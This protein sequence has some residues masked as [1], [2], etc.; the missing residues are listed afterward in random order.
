MQKTFMSVAVIS[1]K[2]CNTDITVCDNF[3]AVQWHRN[4]IASWMPK[5]LTYFETHARIS[6]RDDRVTERYAVS[7]TGDLRYHSRQK[8]ILDR[9]FL[10]QQD[11]M[12]YRASKSCSSIDRGVTPTFH[13]FCPRREPSAFPVVAVLAESHFRPDQQNPSIQN[14]Y[15]AVVRHVLVHHRHTHVYQNILAN[16]G[17]QNGR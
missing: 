4:M 8:I 6:G 1:N 14:G 15:P 7:L 10:M 11:I 9:T 17:F 13:Y 2:S 5:F 16:A 3:H 12:D